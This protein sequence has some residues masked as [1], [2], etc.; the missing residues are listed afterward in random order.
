MLGTDADELRAACTWRAEIQVVNPSPADGISGS[1]RLGLAALEGRA[2]RRAA[3]L[4]GDQPLL[5]VEQL[6]IVLAAQGAIVV[7][8]FAGVPGNPVVLDNSVWRLAAEMRG[9]RGMSQLFGAHPE[10]VTYLDMPGSNPGVNTAAD[11]EMLQSR[12]RTSP[13]RP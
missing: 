11:L 3:V 4:L 6:R 9:D 1:V 5:S 2:T 7:P 12:R 8:R 13:I 10:L